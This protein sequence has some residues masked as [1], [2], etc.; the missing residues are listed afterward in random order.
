MMGNLSTLLADLGDRW[1]GCARELTEEVATGL[2]LSQSLYNLKTAAVAEG[3]R[4]EAY[5][6][7]ARVFEEVDL[8][9]AA[10]NPDVAFAADA[11][12][13]NSRRSFV[14]AARGTAA[15]RLAL[16]SGL[17][18]LRGLA[19]VAPALPSMLLDRVSRRYPDL[20]NT[21]ALTMIANL[22]GNPAVSVPAGLV[23]GLP[24]GMQVMSRHHADALLFDVA[25]TIERSTPWPLVAPTA[26][27]AA[28][29]APA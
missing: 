7:L 15:A 9:V 18:A 25:L 23:H 2:Y 14:D 4:V 27:G 28:L 21:G 17:A 5:R 1:P 16:R 26:P 24:V 13:S 19:A 29:G 10:T 8:V 6:E 22:Y 3:R 20:V 12:M 11:P